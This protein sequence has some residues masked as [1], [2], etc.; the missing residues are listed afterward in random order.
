MSDYD[1]TLKLTD[2]EFK[3]TK[4]ALRDDYNT[5][6]NSL[7]VR[8]IGLVA[9]L[10]TLFQTVQNSQKLSEIF[11]NLAIVNIDLKAFGINLITLFKLLLFATAV[12]I[13]LFFIFRSFFKF[14]LQSVYI[15][16]LYWFE[17][18]DFEKISPEDKQRMLKEK[19]PLGQLHEAIGMRIS[20]KLNNPKRLKLWNTF[21]YDLFMANAS[22]VSERW[23]IF[24][25]G[26]FAFGSTA[27]LF[28]IIW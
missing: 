9:A 1:Y 15:T 24:W 7:G 17:K 4:N 14:A 13:V 25:C 16:Q 27:T 5:H 12:M 23:G 20:G 11:P 8:I 26:V 6:Q 18:K 28:F 22:W 10:F 21:P 3:E 19:R 2:E